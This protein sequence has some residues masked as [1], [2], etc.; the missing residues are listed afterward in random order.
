MRKT[1]NALKDSQRQTGRKDENGWL[2]I[3][4]KDKERKKEGNRKRHRKNG[5]GT[6]E[7][8]TEK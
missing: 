6:K 2:V 8:Q 1:G 3:C 7:R 4:H 5:Q